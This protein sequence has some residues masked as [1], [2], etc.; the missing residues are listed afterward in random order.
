M[1]AETNL[2]GVFVSSALMTACVAWVGL[3]F[4]GRLLRRIGFYGLVW[5]RSLVDIAL[6]AILWALSVMALP[7]LA[8][9]IR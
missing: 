9:L 6:F 2:S 1:I 5:H 8:G 7:A 4:L 3:A